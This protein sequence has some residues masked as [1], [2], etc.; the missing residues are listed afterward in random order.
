MERS[1]FNKVTHLIVLVRYFLPSDLIRATEWTTNNNRDSALHH[2]QSRQTG[3]QNAGDHL[4]RMSAVICLI[5]VGFYGRKQLVYQGS[6]EMKGDYCYWSG[7]GWYLAE[8]IR[9]LLPGM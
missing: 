2:T 4:R 3:T 8:K 1:G 7:L 6:G 5:Y 9:V